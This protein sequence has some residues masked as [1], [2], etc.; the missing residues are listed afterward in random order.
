MIRPE[1]RLD[2]L[3]G[4]NPLGFLTALGV[5]TVM[6][7]SYPKTSLHWEMTGRG[8]APV[9]SGCV[10]DR[11]YLVTKLYD[12]LKETTARHVFDTPDK[13]PFDH[14]QLAKRMI[15]IR[16]Q[17]SVSNRRSADMLAAFGSEMH[18]DDKGCFTSSKF[19]MVRNIDKLP[20]RIKDNL[21]LLERRHLESTLFVTWTND[22]Q[23]K[24]LRWD[25]DAD[26]RHALEGD[27]P[28][29]SNTGM[30]AANCLAAEALQFYPTMSDG[31]RTQTTG[32]TRQNGK[33]YFVWPIWIPAIKRRVLRSL[34]GIRYDN[35]MQLTRMGIV[36]VYESMRISG[37]HYGNFGPAVPHH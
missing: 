19:R 10:T 17:T 6:S 28:L 31:H 16:A 4:G 30:L 9:L 29:R 21:E 3:N 26:R 32:F 1:L 20:C 7:Q 22:E 33:W 18:T 25:P 23:C 13:F 8:W 11:E 14:S 12:G 34:L 24:P 2:G 37:E 5:V 27:K 35:R 36:Q 15:D